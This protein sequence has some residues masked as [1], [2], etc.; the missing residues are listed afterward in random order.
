MA[1]GLAG[2]A[3]TGAAVSLAARRRHRDAAD[4]T[5]LATQLSTGADDTGAL[6]AGVPSS[7]TAD[8]GVRLS[9]EE[10]EPPP[11]VPPTSPSSSSTASRSTG[12]P[13][14]S[15]AGSSPSWPTPRSGR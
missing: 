5:G 2:A 12:G 15:S 3:A 4:R 7:V 14:T 13:G 11:G 8:D 10:I 9:C 6:P 1:G